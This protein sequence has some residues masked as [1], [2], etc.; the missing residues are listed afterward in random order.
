MFAF[1]FYHGPD[2]VYKG[3]WQSITCVAKYSTSVIAS[4][5][6]RSF[7]MFTR[8]SILSTIETYRVLVRIFNE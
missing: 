3:S 7:E 4:T 5:E 2:L 6:N 1:P 8:P